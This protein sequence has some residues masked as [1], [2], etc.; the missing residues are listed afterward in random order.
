MLILMACVILT[1]PEVSVDVD[2]DAVADAEMIL[3][4]EIRLLCGLLK[5][6]NEQRQMTNNEHLKLG[7]SQQQ[8]LMLMLMLMLMLSWGSVNWKWLSGTS[9]YLG[10]ILHPPK[11]PDGDP[12]GWGHLDEP[13]VSVDVDAD[14]DAE[15]REC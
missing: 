14:A 8:K 3:S 13:E 2:A 15:L 10:D 9:P 1:E 7:P 5:K 4:W 12:D 6:V 11:V